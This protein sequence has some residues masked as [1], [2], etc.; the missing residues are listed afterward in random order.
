VICNAGAREVQ[1]TMLARF[2]DRKLAVYVIWFD[3]L[4]DDSRDRW[5]PVMH[6]P[7]VIN[8][9]DEQRFAGRYYANG[10]GYLFDAIYDYYFLY[11]PD[12]T[13]QDRPGGW[14]SSGTTVIDKADQL[15]TAIAAL[16]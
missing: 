9:W 3:M 10:R 16:R 5:R 11:G 2:P 14:D 13:W 12:A 7:R 15:R 4:A 1:D 8:F 6:D